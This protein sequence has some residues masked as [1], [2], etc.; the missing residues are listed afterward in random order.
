VSALPRINQKPIKIKT[1]PNTIPVISI[2]L[3]L[4]LYRP[5]LILCKSILPHIIAG[6]ARQ[7]T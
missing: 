7:I 6:M 2:P 3:P 5:D 1:D 4:I